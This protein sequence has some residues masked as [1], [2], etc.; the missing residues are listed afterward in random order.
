MG[1]G[2]IQTNLSLGEDVLSGNAHVACVDL[3]IHLPECKSTEEKHG[4]NHGPS[5]HNACLAMLSD[6]KKRLHVCSTYTWPGMRATV[7]F[8]SK[9]ATAIHNTLSPPPPLLLYDAQ[10]SYVPCIWFYTCMRICKSRTSKDERSQQL[11]SGACCGARTPILAQVS[12]PIGHLRARRSIT[13]SL[14]NYTTTSLIMSARHLFG[15]YVSQMGYDRFTSRL[16]AIISFMCLHV[17]SLF[18]H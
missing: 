12:G 14:G 9:C 15:W 4:Y 1:R 7:D 2:F 17:A 8:F 3:Y 13:L 10:G 16:A 5:Q 6:V 11:C 18:N